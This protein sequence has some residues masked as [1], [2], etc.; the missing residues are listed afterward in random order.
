MSRGVTENGKHETKRSPLVASCFSIYF[1]AHDAN[2]LPK[3]PCSPTASPALARS[4][5]RIFSRPSPT[6]ATC[7]MDDGQLTIYPFLQ[8]YSVHV[9]QVQY[10]PSS[11]RSQ[12]ALNQNP[13]HHLPHKS[14]PHKPQNQK[15]WRY[16]SWRIKL[17][18]MGSSSWARSLRGIF[19]LSTPVPRHLHTCTPKGRSW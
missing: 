13:K 14:L 12:E 7:T 16:L 19:R 8:G 6:P 10:V 9:D 4:L 5:I 15:S 2:T 11:L 18:G 3:R 17:V 1:Q